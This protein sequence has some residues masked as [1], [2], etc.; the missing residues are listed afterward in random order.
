MRRILKE[1]ALAA[2]LP[3]TAGTLTFATSWLVWFLTEPACVPSATMACPK[4]PWGAYITHDVLGDCYIRTFIA[5]SVTGGSDIML[6]IREL[7]NREKD[8]KIADERLEQEKE[9][10]EQE[11]ERNDQQRAEDLKRADQQRAEDLERADR[12]RAEE[13]ERNDRMLALTENM[14]QQAADR[15]AAAEERAAEERRAAEARA[16]AAEERAQANAAAA[17]AAAQAD[18]Q[19]LADALARFTDALE[20]NANRNGHNNR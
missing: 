18:R 3:T 14:M 20:R 5:I 11:K 17:Q 9:R 10:Y 6:F 15:A 8:K 1:I 2:W 4:L 12:I 7:R 19:L 16:Q 13:R